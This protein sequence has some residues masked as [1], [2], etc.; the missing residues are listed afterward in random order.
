M[1][2]VSLNQEMQQTLLKSC[3][4]TLELN[5]IVMPLLNKSV[6]VTCAV[7]FPCHK[8]KLAGARAPW[9]GI[10]VSCGTSKW[11]IGFFSSKFTYLFYMYECSIYMYA[12][13][14]E[15]HQIPL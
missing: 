1:S 8:P 2:V 12:C 3:H 11:Y 5:S 13:L 7:T 15:G 9:F 6:Q 10:F 4:T 14:P